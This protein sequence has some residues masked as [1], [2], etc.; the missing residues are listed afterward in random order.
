ME[1]MIK[2]TGKV[3]R[4]YELNLNEGLELQCQNDIPINREVLETAR[5][6]TLLQAYWHLLMY[7][8]N[9]AAQKGVS[10]AAVTKAYKRALLAMRKKAA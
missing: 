6:S 5:L 2:T 7:Y 8:N 4:L 3:P 9:K 10:P 1:M